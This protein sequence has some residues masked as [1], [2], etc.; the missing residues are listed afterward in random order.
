MPQVLL[1][2]EWE[3]HPFLKRISSHSDFDGWYS[4]F[5]I[6]NPTL[7]EIDFAEKVEI[8]YS[9]AGGEW[10]SS[11][12]DDRL[13]FMDFVSFAW[14]RSFVFGKTDPAKFAWPAVI[15]D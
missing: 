4:Y 15:S 8:Q 10:I 11:P 5:T 6:K 3:H 12:F 1:E 9:M 14:D 13:S 7:D 2:S